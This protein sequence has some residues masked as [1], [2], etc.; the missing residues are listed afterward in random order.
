MFEEALKEVKAEYQKMEGKPEWASPSFWF[1]HFGFKSDLNK[2]IEEVAH[3]IKVFP[4]TIHSLKKLSKEYK[5]VLVSASHKS[6][7]S[8]K[9][10]VEGFGGY[11]YK[12]ISTTSDLGCPDKKPETYR[13]I[14]E[15]LNAKPDEIIHIG[16]DYSADYVNPRKAGI[17]AYLIDRFNNAEIRQKVKNKEDII[18]DLGELI[19]HVDRCALPSGPSSV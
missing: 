2:V 4:D 16:D 10:N 8:R 15:M 13:K 1:K 14:L 19:E 18:S 6:F 9:I 7:L 5:L 11:F 3:E 12:I 17:R